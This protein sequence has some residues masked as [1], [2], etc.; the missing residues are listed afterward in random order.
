MGGVAAIAIGKEMYL[1]EPVKSRRSRRLDILLLDP[2]PRIVQQH[3]QR[4]I[5]Q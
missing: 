2:H 1:H 5:S 4:G 3:A